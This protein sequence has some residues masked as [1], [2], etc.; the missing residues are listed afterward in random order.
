MKTWKP[1]NAARGLDAKGLPK[2]VVTDAGRPGG[3]EKSQVRTRA[4]SPLGFRLDEP[5]P[6]DVRTEN[7]PPSATIKTVEAPRKSFFPVIVID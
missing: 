6:V 5:N 4:R 1:V 3:V 7:R 2:I